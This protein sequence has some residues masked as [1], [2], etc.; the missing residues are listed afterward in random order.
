MS[1]RDLTAEL[2]AARVVAPNHVR[3]QVRLISA[4]ATPPTRRFTWR[5]TLVIALPVAAAVA[6][7][8][9]VAQP[10]PQHQATPAVLERSD[11]A[12]APAT[13]LQQGAVTKSAAGIAAPPSATRA[14]HYGAFLSL[15]I[16][17]Q[18]GVSDGVKRALA[19]TS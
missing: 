11:L 14:Q 2:R 9:I 7:A 18:K 16:G 19:I 17:T 6:A 15:R 8:V 1:Q 10:S 12:P 3:A 4:A 5:R 13:T